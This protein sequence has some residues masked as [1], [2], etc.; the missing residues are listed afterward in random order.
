M[1]INGPIHINLDKNRAGELKTTVVKE[2][3]S[4]PGVSDEQLMDA[5]SGFRYVIESMQ[6]T[7]GVTVRTLDLGVSLVEELR[8]RSSILEKHFNER[9]AEMF[10]ENMGFLNKS[11]DELGAIISISRYDHIH[12]CKTKTAQL[13]QMQEAVKLT[14]YF[15]ANS[16]DDSA[17]D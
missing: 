7:S 9:N 3:G 10:E 15:E 5:L 2:E 6:N 8:F 14:S 13:E 17:N 16:N 12:G 11:I 4:I 1:L